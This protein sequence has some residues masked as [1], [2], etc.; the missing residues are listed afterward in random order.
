MP[1]LAERIEALE[2]LKP[3]LRAGATEAD[4]QVLDD[5]VVGIG[6]EA[7]RVAAK[8][9]RIARPPIGAADDGA[10]R[11]GKRWPERI[12]VRS[13]G[14][15]FHLAVEPN[16]YNPEADG[17]R[18]D[19]KFPRF[20]KF[21]REC[22]DSARQGVVSPNLK[23]LGEADLAGGGALVPEEFRAQ[24][25][26]VALE[27]AVVRPR[28]TVFPMARL[29]LRIPAIHDTSHATNVFGG[30]QVYIV[31]ETTPVAGAAPTFKQILFTAKKIMGNTA[32]GNE[33]VED[34]PIALEAL[35]VLLFGRAM[36]WWEDE[37]FINGTGG[38][39]PLGILTSPALISV[40]K[41]TGQAAATI[42]AEN[43]DKMWS[44]LLPQAKNRAVW[45]ANPDISPQLMSMSRNVGTG[46]MPV[47][48]VNMAGVGPQTMYNRPI[49]YTEHCQTL[50][51][52]GDL[53]LVDLSYYVIADR[54]QLAI[55]SSEHVNFLSDSMVWRFI[56][57]LDGK[58]WLESA[59]M[60]RYGSNSLS[61]FVAL[62]A[63][64]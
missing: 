34:S 8:S 19:G 14:Q 10:G 44:R 24:L 62:A 54:Q 6:Q 47:M 43:I 41:E 53:Y 23:A 9:Q 36:A 52:L 21:L 37:W 27:E 16:I 15:E 50:G 49:I 58:P 38:G 51:A 39:Q 2:D 13:Y 45:L 30:V 57:R 61:P 29:E 64:V 42:V 46:G 55:S 63:R 33:L 31:G 3:R 26:M 35:L 17:V 1:T 56:E 32:V 5:T 4:L 11:S 48:M 22:Y 25:L 7:G 59:I 28:A 18:L 60:P 12:M 20:S 40:A